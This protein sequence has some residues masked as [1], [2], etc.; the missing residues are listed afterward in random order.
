MSI[1]SSHRSTSGPS[2]VSA[3]NTAMR[4]IKTADASWSKP[5]AMCCTLTEAST[6]LQQISKYQRLMIP[7]PAH[8][9]SETSSFLHKFITMIM[10]LQLHYL[11]IWQQQ[12]KKHYGTSFKAHTER[13]IRNKNDLITA[14]WAQLRV[15]SWS[16]QQESTQNSAYVR[17]TVE[18]RTLF[19]PLECW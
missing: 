18:T 15:I 8:I 9:S 14:Q 19:W 16:T 11:N 2:S 3:R 4:A 10:A 12:Y 6:Q 5:A 7:V 17:A 13:W 1:L